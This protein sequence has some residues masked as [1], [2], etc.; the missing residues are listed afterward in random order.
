[1]KV[2]RQV[3]RILRDTTESTE[4]ISQM[5]S[6]KF[7]GRW[8]D[9]VEIKPINETDLVQFVISAFR[10]A[11]ETQLS[12]P[13]PYQPAASW[14]NKGLYVRWRTYYDAISRGDLSMVAGL[15]RNFFRNEGISGL[16]GQG[17]VF[18]RFCRLDKISQ[19]ARAHTMVEHYIVWRENLPLTPMKEL[20]AP[21]VGNP[22]GY[23][24]HGMLMY[25]PVFEY[26][27]QAHYFSQLLR[28]L[29]TPVVLEIGGGFG[30]LAYHL[31]RCSPAIK[32]IGLDLPENILIQTYYL[33]SIFPHLRMLTYLKDSSRLD[34]NL[35]DHYDVVLLPSFELP[36]IASELIDLTVNVRSLSEMSHETI[37]EYHRQ[38]DRIGRLYFFHENI[39][40]ARLDGLYGI[41]SSEFP[42]LKNF[43]LIVSSESRWP[44]YQRKSSYPCRENLYIHRRTLR[45][46]K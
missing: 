42:S 16:W 17:D 18:G 13:P 12:A 8:V 22:W 15:L 14:G 4:V 46:S 30:G 32:Y 37:S 28:G 11:K 3:C 9:S 40:K 25:E 23:R 43:T 34:R 33:S 31:L 24:F 41:P 2:T 44:K 39:Y 20:D 29:Q 10:R 26:N 27:F 6:V 35:L 1:M 7:E 36:R 38:I 19:L 21:R 45:A 5:D